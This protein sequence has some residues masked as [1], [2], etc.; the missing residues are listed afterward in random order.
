MTAIGLQIPALGQRAG[1]AGPLYPDGPAH[2]RIL[3]ILAANLA[4][5]AA[6]FYSENQLWPWQARMDLRTPG[7]GLMLAQTVVLGFAV[8]LATRA[9]WLAMMLGLLAAT[10]LG[11]AFFYSGMWLIDPRRALEIAFLISRA[12]EVGIVGTSMLILGVA[13]RLVLRQRL[14]LESEPSAEATPQ[15]QLRELMFLIAACALGL[16]LSNLFAYDFERELQVFALVDSL[17]RAAPAALPW[18]WLV[19][20]PRV[21][22]RAIVWVIVISVVLAGMKIVLDHAL[23]R[24]E[25]YEILCDARLRAAALTGGA[26]FNGVLLRALGFR[27]RR[28]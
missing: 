6:A 1:S 2:A 18:L 5:V 3:I 23:T 12:V 10:L 11:Y 9:G 19:T 25:A 28:G 14:A 8:G 13:V 15:Y 24:E 17:A 26:V 27:W 16:G 7:L 22:L 20:Q 4:L 21:T